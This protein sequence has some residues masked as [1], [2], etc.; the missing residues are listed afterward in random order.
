V[1]F[2]KP[3]CTYRTNHPSG[4]FYH[5]KGRTALVLAGK[6]T[7]SGVRFNLSLTW[8]GFEPGTWTTV[9][10]ETFDTEDEAYAAEEKLVS[11]ESLANP[12]CLNMMCGGRKGKYKTP[13]SLLKRF[14]SEL[15]RQRAVELRAKAKL[16]AAAEKAKRAEKA[17]EQRA[18]Q[19]EK[20]RSLKAKAAGSKPKRK[21][22]RSSATPTSAP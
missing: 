7:G 22:L 18:R 11:H 9:V 21:Q 17:A 3:W 16:R 15:K 1:N 5:G 10:L 6:Y 12:F 19:Q 20:L 2:D 13:S 4:H 14:R 8:P